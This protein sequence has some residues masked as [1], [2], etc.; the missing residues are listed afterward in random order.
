MTRD[1]RRYTTDPSISAGHIADRVVDE[2]WSQTRDLG[3]A[4]VAG[5]EAFKG[6][7]KENVLDEFPPCPN[8]Q[9]ACFGNPGRV[10][11]SHVGFTYYCH[12]CGDTFD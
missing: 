8:E 2:V 6:V 3:Q 7:L 5:S 1:Q 12:E 10:A 4:L 11:Y 9:C